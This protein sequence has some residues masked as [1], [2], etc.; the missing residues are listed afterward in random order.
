M[1][2][3]NIREALSLTKRFNFYEE[4]QRTPSFFFMFIYFE[5]SFSGVSFTDIVMSSFI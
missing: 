2:P 4:D 5:F 3:D 1:R